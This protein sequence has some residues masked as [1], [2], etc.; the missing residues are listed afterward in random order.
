M[1][2]IL[3][4][5]L[6]SDIFEYIQTVLVTPQKKENIHLEDTFI[7]KNIFTYCLKRL[8]SIIYAAKLEFGTQSFIYAAKLEIGTQNFIPA[9][10]L[11]QNY[12][13]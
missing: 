12:L 13:P 10:N 1:F 4:H 8:Y 5:L 3:G 7:I 6:Y 2:K 9:G 11:N